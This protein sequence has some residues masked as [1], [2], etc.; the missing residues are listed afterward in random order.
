MTEGLHQRAAVA[1]VWRLFTTSEGYKATGVAQAEVDL[2]I[3]GEIRSHYDPKGTARATPR[4]S[5]TKSS[6][7]S[8]ERMLAIR[9]QA[10]ARQPSASQRNRRNLDRALFQSRRRQHDPGAHRRARLS[11]IRRNRR[12]CAS[13]SRTAIA[14]RSITSPSR[15]GRSA[16]D[17]SCR[18]GRIPR[19]SAAFRYA[20]SAI[21][22]LNRSGADALDGSQ[23]HRE[24]TRRRSLPLRRSHGARSARL[25]EV[26]P[27]ASGRSSRRCRF[28]CA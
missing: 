13:S 20:S 6:P 7:T 3:G 2:R 28:R 17:A 23:V 21:A 19:S 27:R 8:P 12:R 18:A 16:R 25:R 5:S 15:T 14:G 24:R 11:T 22:G 9:D 4:R 10:G 26:L 1:E